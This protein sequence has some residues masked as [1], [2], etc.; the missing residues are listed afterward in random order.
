VEKRSELAIFLDNTFYKGLFEER[1][2][3]KSPY[4]EGKKSEVAIF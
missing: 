4:F 2:P 3:P 1:K